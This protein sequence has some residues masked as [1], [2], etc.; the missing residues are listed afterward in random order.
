[1]WNSHAEHVTS[2]D[3]AV[4]KGRGEGKGK[5]GN[6]DDLYNAVGGMR[7]GGEK[8]KRKMDEEEESRSD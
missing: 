3:K 1:V 6:A 5:G 7:G 8:G 2:S 4:E